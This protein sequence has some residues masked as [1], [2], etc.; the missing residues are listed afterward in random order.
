[1]GPITLFDKSFLQ[2][3]S[4]DE[5]VLFDHFFFSVISPL[6]FV[7]TLADLE[8]AVRKGRT[9]EQE[10]GIIA[11][12]VPEMSGSPVV[13]HSRL[14]FENLLGKNLPMDGRVP[15]SGATPV[16]FEGKPGLIYDLPPEAAAFDRWQ[17]GEFLEVERHYARAWREEL[18][19]ADLVTLAAGMKAMGIDSRNCKSL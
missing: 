15:A 4:I 8:K 2:S 16:R 13:H 3:L 12:K 10:V 6:F 7:E 19:S 5:S 17:K 11:D 9:P 14:A 1:M 18:A